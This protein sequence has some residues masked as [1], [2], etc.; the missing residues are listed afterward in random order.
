MATVLLIILYILAIGLGIPDSAF[1]SAWPAMYLDFGIEMSMANVVS[2]L[3]SGGTIIASLSSARLINKFGTAT[4]TAVSTALTVIALFGY[5]LSPNI[6]VICLLAI[7]MGFGGGAVDAAIN[8][9][10]ALRYSAMY[11]NFMHCFYGVGVMISPYI[12]SWALRAKDWRHGYILAGV[13]Q[14]I[15][16]IVAIVA[17][18]LW[19]KVKCQVEG[20]EDTPPRTLKF[21][22]MLK[23]PSVL[24]ASLFFFAS[25]SVESLCT[26]WCSTYMVHTKGF[27]AA[28]A[29]GYLVLYFLGLTVGRILSGLL[30]GR[31]S[32]WTLLKVGICFGFIGCIAV[33]LSSEPIL[34]MAGLFFI[35]C[36]VAPV[37]PGLTFLTPRNFGVDV[38]QSVTGFEFS[39]AYTGTMI[40]P[41]LFGAFASLVS[42]Y[43]FPFFV[44]FFEA[45]MVICNVSLVRSLKK[46]GKFVK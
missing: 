28:D 1:G 12:M 13:L 36:G 38:S 10:M 14:A 31:V 33:F 4:V 24:F 19:K 11:M 29:A 21:F 9:Y 41:I 39:F 30:S 43:A 17:I 3:V 20:E 6:W 27:S 7:P 16:A 37:F 45:L 5:A 15:I 18:P 42:T 22:E 2:F 35:G 23:T 26:V 32:T 44:L 40:S 8:N 46:S 25:T 34:M